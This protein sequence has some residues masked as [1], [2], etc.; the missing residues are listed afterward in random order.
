[1]LGVHYQLPAFPITGDC[2]IIIEFLQ[3]TK[4]TPF[5]GHFLS[6]RTQEIV[7]VPLA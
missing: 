5:I 6:D 7:I 3:C 4:N 2:Q 1:M